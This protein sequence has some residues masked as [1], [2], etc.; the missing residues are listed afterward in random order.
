MCNAMIICQ[1]NPS[2]AAHGRQDRTRHLASTVTQQLLGL[3]TPNQVYWDHHGPQMVGHVAIRPR[4]GLII[5]LTHAHF[6]NCSTNP[7]A[8]LTY[9]SYHASCLTS[10]KQSGCE[11]YS[12]PAHWG[13]VPPSDLLVLVK[14]TFNLEWEWTIK[15]YSPRFLHC[16]W[17]YCMLVELQ[18]KLALNENNLIWKRKMTTKHT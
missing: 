15:P 18:M 6:F 3:V 11:F 13:R 8:V 9:F 16:Y 1:V 4:Q 7:A 17:G 12:G 14:T 5:L 10:S 2:G